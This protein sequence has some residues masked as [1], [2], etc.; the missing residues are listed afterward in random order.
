MRSTELL[1][2][3]LCGR[4]FP[5]AGN[6]AVEKVFAFALQLSCLAVVLPCSC[7]VT[8]RLH[9]TK[10]RP[11]QQERWSSTIVVWRPDPMY[12]LY[13]SVSWIEL[14]TKCCALFKSRCNLYVTY[15]VFACN[16]TKVLNELLRHRMIMQCLPSSMNVSRLRTWIVFST[17]YRRAHVFLRPKLA[18]LHLSQ[19]WILQLMVIPLVRV[20]TK[21]YRRGTCQLIIAIL[22]GKSSFH[23][24]NEMTLV[25]TSAA[26]FLANSAQSFVRTFRDARVT[27]TK[28]SKCR[29]FL[30]KFNEHLKI[31]GSY[32]CNLEIE[33][34]SPFLVHA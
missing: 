30:K 13:V 2:K 27:R 3:R 4:F 16:E 22:N 19:F 24:Q 12:V 23:R 15:F 7:H 31:E 29:S 21:I 28:N 1:D 14:M 26:N 33:Y 9:N 18:A 5:I 8:K 10:K 20:C 32:I 34:Y 25:A 11:G 17:V 6:D